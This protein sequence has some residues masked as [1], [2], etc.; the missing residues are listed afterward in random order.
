MSMSQQNTPLVWLS[1]LYFAKGIAY[2]MVMFLS[3]IMLKQMGLSSSSALS[4]VALFYIPWITKFWWKPYVVRP[5]HFTA[6]IAVSEL[7][8]AL[9]FALLSFFMASASCTIVMLL[10]VAWL[11]AIHNVAVDGLYRLLTRDNHLPTFVRVKELA[12]K[13]AVIVGQGVLVM[14]VG[15]L[16]VFYRYD[17]FYSWQATFYILAGM[18]LLFCMWHRAILP[19]HLHHAEDAIRRALPSLQD[20]GALYLFVYPFAVGLQAKVGILFLLDAPSSGG[21][22]LSPQEF[23]LVMGTV[24]ITG[25]TI[26]GMLGFRVLRRDGLSRWLWP[27]ALLMVVPCAVYALMGYWEP[28]DLLTISLGVLLEQTSYGFGFAAYLWVLRHV[29]NRELGKSLMALSLMASCLLSGV[30]QS[31]VGY[32]Y[33]F[34][35]ALVLSAAPLVSTWII[36]KNPTLK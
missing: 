29:A 3:L 17:R 33:T 7:L 4:C 5:Q 13:M 26:G 9:S 34:L 10:L 36:R 2:V 22:G 11:T 1:T 35:I 15:N 21:L 30:L 19:R 12:R 32:Y 24:G 8:L 25:L 14:M 18:F 20:V 27:M 16:Q 28:S 31:A 6:W 23:G